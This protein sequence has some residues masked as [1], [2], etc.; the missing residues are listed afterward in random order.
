MAAISFVKH[1]VKLVVNFSFTLVIRTIHSILLEGSRLIRCERKAV[2]VIH[3]LLI[4]HTAATHLK[5]PSEAT[6]SLAL[7][8]LLLNPD[9]AFG[10]A[11]AY[12][13]H[14]QI[15]GLFQ[16]SITNYKNKTQSQI[17]STIFAS[18]NSFSYKHLWQLTWTLFLKTQSGCSLVLLKSFLNFC[19]KITNH[20]SLLF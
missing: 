2:S 11:S 8:V 13:K 1:F 5:F 10:P 20:M 12:I 7:V 19:F 9:M 15:W 3:S 18:F 4:W 6:L 16:M 17:L 14:G